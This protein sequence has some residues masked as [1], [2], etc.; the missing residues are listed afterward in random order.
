MNCII[1]NVAPGTQV[2]FSGE[3]LMLCNSWQCWFCH[4]KKSQSCLLQA[5]VSKFQA[6]SYQPASS[7][8][9]L[10]ATQVTQATPGPGIAIE[11]TEL[12][13]RSS[14]K[15][16]EP[17][18]SDLS[19]SSLPSKKLKTDYSTLS[20]PIRK[21]PISKL[22]EKPK[23]LSRASSLS[24]NSTLCIVPSKRGRPRK[25]PIHEAV[26]SKTQK[27]RGIVG[28]PIPASLADSAS[29]AKSRKFKLD[30][31]MP[32]GPENAEK[33]L[34][35]YLTS[36]ST[37]LSS[38]YVIFL[39]N[40]WN[41]DVDLNNQDVVN[42]LKA[43]Y[44]IFFDAATQKEKNDYKKKASFWMKYHTKLI[45]RLKADLGLKDVNTPEIKISSSPKKPQLNN[46]EEVQSDGETMVVGYE[47]RNYSD[48]TTEE[49]MDTEE[50][51]E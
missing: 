46:R 1:C 37:R 33:V 50:N 22:P 18:K 32:F 21:T 26:T 14:L 39:L 41:S 15:R 5:Y 38:K 25:Q 23:I 48:F 35:Y 12:P 4:C 19:V 30:V 13:R 20:V 44:E 8:L 28:I 36:I 2:E 49:N 47:G 3:V 45:K 40:I 6:L 42:N 31:S 10:Q 27:P 9:P 17:H 51:T 16:K 24:P 11:L 43:E 34:K 7:V 29:D